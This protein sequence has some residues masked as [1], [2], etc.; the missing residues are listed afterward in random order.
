MKGTSL[1]CPQ[2]GAEHWGGNGTENIRKNNYIISYLKKEADRVPEKKD[3]PVEIKKEC[4]KHGKEEN[5]FCQESGCQMP[6][7]ISC[8][9]DEHKGHKISD[10]EEVTEEICVA[11]L[12]DIRWMKETLH[13]KKD[14]FVTVQKIVS[15]NCQDCTSYILNLKADLMNKI[16]QIAGNLVQDIA[17][18]K[19]KTDSRINKAV[20]NSGVATELYLF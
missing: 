9:K 14:D 18:Q 17:E 4:Q 12:E 8:L 2:C 13:K 1:E 7:C 11:L 3:S 19:D 5:L 10:L 20:A 16:N 6:I 15:Q